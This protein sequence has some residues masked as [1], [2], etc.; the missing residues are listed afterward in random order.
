MYAISPDGLQIVYSGRAGNESM[1]Y[2]RSMDQLV[3]TPIAGTEGAMHAAFSADGRWLAF[4]TRAELRKIPV[5]G[6]SPSTLATG[7]RTV[8]G[9]TWVG[10]DRLVFFMGGAL[11]S[12][13]STGGTPTVAV[14]AAGSG[15]KAARAW[16]LSL[17]KDVVV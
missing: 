2:L 4:T 8:V 14:A 13:P 7:L 16:T 5:A 17:G 9:L 15:T 11:M 1:L 6:G 3:A 10:S 12:V